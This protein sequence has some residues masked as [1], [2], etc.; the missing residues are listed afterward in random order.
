MRQALE[1]EHLELLNDSHFARILQMGGHTFSVMFLHYI[2]SRLH[3]GESGLLDRDANERGIGRG[4]GTAKARASASI[5]DEL[6][7][8]EEKPTVGFL[9]PTC[10]TTNIR[11]EVVSKLTSLDNFLKYPW[12]RE[13]FLLTVRSTKS[14]T[15]MN[16]VQETMAIQGFSHAMVL[17]T[18]TA[19]PSIIIKSGGGDPL[20]DSALSTA[21]II[22]SVVERKLVVNLV[23]AK[24]VD[25]LGQSFVCTDVDGDLLN[26]GLGNKAD[27]SVANMVS[28][29]E[30]EYPFEHN[31]WSGGVNS[32]DVKQKKCPPP[33]SESSDDNVSLTTEMGNVPQGGVDSGMQSGDRRGQ[34]S[35]QPGHEPQNVPLDI[36]TLLRMAADAYEEMV[37]TMFEGYVLSLKGHFNR[38]VGV[39]RTD[40]Q[41]ATTSIRQLETSVTTEFENIK[42]LIKGPGYNDEEPPIGGGSP[43]RQYSP[44]RGPNHDVRD[45]FVPPAKDSGNASAPV[46]A[47]STASPGVSK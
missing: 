34:P 41:S 12:G 13:S 6:F 20:A 19:C 36:P 21:D 14:K 29:I 45:A 40:L 39:L 17:V 46:Y 25:Q 15:P 9:C 3:C 10:G 24:S 4:K 2:L 27:S 42:K 22:T 26:H 31:T 1:D 44:Y 33:T 7:H 30:E 43:Y 35:K 38:E 37:M 28:L 8:G 47:A 16:Y 5:W 18:V 11:P 32:D 23:T